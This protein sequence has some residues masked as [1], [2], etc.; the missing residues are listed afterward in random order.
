MLPG[1]QLA[2]AVIGEPLEPFDG[3]LMVGA[4]GTVAGA[5]GVTV[6]DSADKALLPA[7][8]VA[9]TWNRTAVPLVKPVTTKLVEPAAAVRNAPTCVVPAELSTFTE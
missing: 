5:A 8:L 6:L 9:M 1:V 7:E 4:P 2:V 3:L